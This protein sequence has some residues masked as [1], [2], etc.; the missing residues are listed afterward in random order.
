MKI[1]KKIALLVTLTSFI[2]S[3]L[4]FAQSDQKNQQAVQIIANEINQ[5][6]EQGGRLED[7]NGKEIDAAEIVS[8]IKTTAIYIP[9]DSSQLKYLFHS[10]NSNQ[11]VTLAVLKTDGTRLAARSFQVDASL[12]PSENV[13]KL[14]QMLNTLNSEVDQTLASH[15]LQKPSI[16]FPA[17]RM[18]L[19]G[20]IFFT[21]FGGFFMG[22]SVAICVA[23]AGHRGA[24][25]FC[26]VGSVLGAMII[27]GWVD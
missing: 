11:S 26:G 10:N 8:G 15:V 24:I 17:G 7:E 14:R 23:G 22:I 27:I 25:P 4:A 13:L 18:P 3:N 12:S 9:A 20:K 1:L 5:I 6:K 16:R 19:F 21:I 2:C